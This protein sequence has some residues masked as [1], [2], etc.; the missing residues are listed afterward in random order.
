[1][2][3]VDAL[4]KFHAKLDPTFSARLSR[5]GCKYEIKKSQ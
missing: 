5:I 3:A 2:K 4:G 1:M